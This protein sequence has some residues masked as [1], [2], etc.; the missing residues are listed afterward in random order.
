MKNTPIQN[1]QN[2]SPEERKA[3][4][5]R[6]GRASGAARHQKKLWRE[7][8]ELIVSGVVTEQAADQIRKKFNIDPSVPLTHQDEIIAAI[9]DKAKRGDKDA[10]QFLRDTA[11]QNPQT[12]VKIGN[13]DDKPFETLDL[14]SLTD[15]QLHKLASR[16]K[17]GK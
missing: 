13:L 5:S 15:E 11:G 10:A 3:A 6:G 7:S 1:F 8:V 17:G 4:A 9:T 12:M 16:E 14:S 2:L